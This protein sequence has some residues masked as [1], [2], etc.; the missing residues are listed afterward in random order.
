MSEWC[1]GSQFGFQHPIYHSLK[2]SFGGTSQLS[3]IALPKGE[4]MTPEVGLCVHIG[5][6]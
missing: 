3:A 2:S 1:R 6:L 5:T 4:K